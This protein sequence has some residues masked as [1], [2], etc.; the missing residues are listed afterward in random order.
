LLYFIESE[1]TKDPIS[2]S[3]AINDVNSTKWIDAMKDELKSMNHNQVWEVVQLPPGQKVVGCKWVFKTKRDC[4]GK[5]ERY[6]DR[7]VFKRFNRKKALT[8][9]K[10]FLLFLGKTLL[11]L[12][13][14]SSSL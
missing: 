8:I 10:L 6:K 11:E 13:C 1:G 12:S 5:I 2:Y 14:V 7:L 3:Q 4:N 9:M